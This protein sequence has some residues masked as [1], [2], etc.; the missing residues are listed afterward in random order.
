MEKSDLAAY[1]K[2]NTALGLR[3]VFKYL[4][5][6]AFGCEHLAADYAAVLARAEAEAAAAGEDD[7]PEVEYL[8]GGFCRVHLKALKS[9]EELETLVRLFLLSA[10]PVPDGE[11]RLE[12]G[13]ECLIRLSASGELPFP[14][15]EVADGISAWR[16]N[17]FPPVR[18][19][20]G[21]RSAHRPAY[22]VIRT[23]LLPELDRVRERRISG[24]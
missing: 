1:C 15:D 9:R 20:E 22:R 6:S 7:L 21:F 18:H 8:P 16:E 12:E 4:Y 19:S 24:I 11:G 10:Q 2:E 17:G 13:L 23:D 5:Q 14:E 3:D